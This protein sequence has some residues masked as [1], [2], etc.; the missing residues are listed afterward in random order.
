M[1]NPI[2]HDDILLPPGSSHCCTATTSQ[3]NP[4]WVWTKSVFTFFQRPAVWTKGMCSVV[5]FVFLLS[6]ATGNSSS[7]VKVSLQSDIRVS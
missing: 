4:V 3:W 7:I 1:W 5:L 6:T 2:T